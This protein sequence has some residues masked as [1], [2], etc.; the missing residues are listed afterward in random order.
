M[1]AKLWICEICGDPYI[2]YKNPTNC[3]FCGANGKHIKPFKKA[4]PEF[5]IELNE[6]DKTNAE[7]ALQVETSNSTFYYCAAEKTPEPEAKKLFKALA[8]IETEHASIW[9]KIL[10]L[11]ETPKGTAEC[12]TDYKQNL[13]ESHARESRAI[14][15][16][17]TAAKQS[18]H[19]RIKQIF[20]ALVEVESD[21]LHLS[22]ERGAK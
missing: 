17:K 5:N 14:E 15:F 3:P 19:P 11:N 22:E 10:K 18:T 20:K 12:T 13:N 21:H 8:K 1:K 7:H 2:G 9:K 16:Y 6:K 4:K